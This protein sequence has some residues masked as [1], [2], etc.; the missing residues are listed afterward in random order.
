MIFINQRLIYSIIFY[1]LVIILIVI[2]KPKFIFDENNNVIPFGVGQDKT[3]FPLGYIV[4]SLAIVSYYIFT[5]IDIMSS[6]CI[7]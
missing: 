5:L 3:I 1:T 7:L 6:K 2:S 4:V